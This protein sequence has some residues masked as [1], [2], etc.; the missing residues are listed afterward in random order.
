ME[1]D[2]LLFMAAA[3]IIIALMAAFALRSEAQTKAYRAAR[4]I[5]WAIAAL[6]CGSVIGLTLNPLNAWLVACLGAPAYAAL[7]AVSLF[8]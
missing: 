3:A 7:F 6:F 8:R 1:R 5:F 4:R 2:T